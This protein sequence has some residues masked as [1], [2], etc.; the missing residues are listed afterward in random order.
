MSLHKSLKIK[1][2]LARRRNVLTRT[3][4]LAIMIERGM[5]KEG[6][7]VTGLPKLRTAY[8]M[9]KRK[10]K[11]APEGEEGEGK[12]EEAGKEEKKES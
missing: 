10:K 9:K 1:D 5:W 12:P 7:P 2:E 3:E 4:R 6:D 8:K 11:E